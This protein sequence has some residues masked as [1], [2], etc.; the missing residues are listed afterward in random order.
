MSHRGQR[1]PPPGS[2]RA[3]PRP[4]SSEDQ[5]GE[6]LRRE[7]EFN[8]NLVEIA[9]ALILVLDLQGRILLFNKRL[10]EVTGRAAD[11]VKG[12][13]WIDNFIPQRER[14]RISNIFARARGGAPTR[15]NVNPILAKDGDERIIEWFDA[16]ITDERGRTVAILCTGND[17][18]QRIR[19]EEA[20]L[21][22]AEQARARLA[23]IEA[24][25]V[26]APIGLCEFD[27]E[28]R[29]VRINRR[30]ADMN[31]ATPA[32]HI[33]R[34]PRDMNPAMGDAIEP[35][36][37]RVLEHGEP[38]LG[39]EVEAADPARP[40]DI[41]HRILHYRPIKDAD[42]RTVGVNAA[43]EDVTQRKTL[44]ARLREA[45]RMATIGNLAA[46]LMHDITNIV[47]SMQAAERAIEREGIDQAS[48]AAFQ[49]VKQGTEQLVGFCH[50]LRQ[51]VRE[52]RAD[53]AARLELRQWWS[54]VH[55]LLSLGCA[56]GVRV[57][58]DLP[59]G[60]PPLCVQPGKLTRAVLNLVVNASEAI[61]DAGRDRGTIRVWAAADPD[62]SHI[63]LGV[64]DDGP[65]IP[66]DVR[67]RI[68]EPFFSTKSS[69]LSTGMG[70]SMV[71]AFAAD[72]GGDV[73]VASEP[74]AGATITLTLPAQTSSCCPDS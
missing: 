7:R 6:S 29:Y 16:P 26:S 61:A 37:R 67:D 41:H 60:L 12:R 50:N 3:Q 28:L 11:D 39:V 4:S 71:A 1:R 14:T 10:E 57:H 13:P 47:A 53:D 43:V 21:R 18:T 19:A 52:G 27:A 31:S 69:G 38:L 32:A 55:P 62:A 49:H 22:S 59:D 44:E 70:M 72:A 8:A 40:G 58:G 64:T 63:R 25:Y 5:L 9:P 45:E 33:G 56:R 17:I 48:S 74:G 51:L 34:T 23:E 20:Q 54:Q 42:G 73:H 36:L 30:L 65:G 66:P 2:P 24:I 15:G 35:L 68:F 46:G